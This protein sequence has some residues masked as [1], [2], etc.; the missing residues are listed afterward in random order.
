MPRAGARNPFAQVNACNSCVHTKRVV[1]VVRVDT[2]R[3]S[4]CYTALSF[5]THA[6]GESLMAFII[7]QGVRRT[8]ASGTGTHWAS[9]SASL[10]LPDVPEAA[11]G[12]HT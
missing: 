4:R 8:A 2:A 12:R 3:A 6:R 9:G 7:S 10:L 11:R 1:V 5:H